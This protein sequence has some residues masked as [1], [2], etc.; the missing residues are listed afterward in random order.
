[1]LFCADPEDGAHYQYQFLHG[2][3]IWQTLPPAIVEGPQWFSCNKALASYNTLY[4]FYGTLIHNFGILGLWSSVPISTS[5]HQY[6]SDTRINTQQTFFE[7]M[8]HFLCKP[9]ISTP[10]KLWLQGM[11]PL[12]KGCLYCVQ[13]DVGINIT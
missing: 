5:S 1:M 9:S 12:H 2:V 7:H 6:C 11:F 10:T 4:I 8:S 13:N 3:H